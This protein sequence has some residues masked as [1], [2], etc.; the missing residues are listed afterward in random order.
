MSSFHQYVIDTIKQI[1]FV[2]ETKICIHGIVYI[3]LNCKKEIDYSQT[4][5][6]HRIEKQLL[7]KNKSLQFKYFWYDKKEV[8]GL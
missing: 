2:L 6:I 3:R 8:I 1:P 5:Y 7:D 4:S